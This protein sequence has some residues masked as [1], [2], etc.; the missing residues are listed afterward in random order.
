M[1]K[2]QS[3]QEEKKAT[4]DNPARSAEELEKRMQG[5]APEI[6]VAEGGPTEEEK[7]E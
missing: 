6:K 1:P 5:P 4:L 7:S 2:N 3:L